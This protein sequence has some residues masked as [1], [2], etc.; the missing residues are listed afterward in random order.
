V[1]AFKT[2][3]HLDGLIKKLSDLQQKFSEHH[4]QVCYEA[5]YAK[6]VSQDLYDRN[7]GN[8]TRSLLDG[9]VLENPD[10]EELEIISQ[11][12]SEVTVPTGTFKCT[13]TVAKIKV[14]D[15]VETWTNPKE[16]GFFRHPEFANQ[17][18]SL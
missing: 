6:T 11:D 13:H 5:T 15:L 7:T 2:R 17:L 9:E 16:V 1:V 10:S 18:Y 3:P 4:I 8:L 14:W 12:Y